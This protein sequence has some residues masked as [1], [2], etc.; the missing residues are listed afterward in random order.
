M[1]LTIAELS[2]N[3]NQSSGF[4][5]AESRRTRVCH[6]S[7]GLTTGGLER[8]LVDFARFHDRT[9]Y[10]LTFVALHDLGRPA[11]EIR[12]T[13]CEVHALHAESKGLFFRIRE[14][15]RLFRE[16]EIDVVHTHNLAPHFN[17][18]LAARLAGA[19]VV[20]HTRHGQRFRGSWKSQFLFRSVGRGVSRFVTVS[21][22]AARLCREADGIPADKVTRIWNGI[23]LGRFQ[24]RG[25]ASQPTAISV[26]RLSPEKDFP[27][28]IRAAAVAVKTIPE[29]RL[30]IVGNGAVRPALEQL[31]AEL[32]VGYCVEL[33]GERNDIPELL[34]NAGFFVSSSLTEGV[35][36]TLL[37]AM[38]VGLPIL[39]TN[40]GG[41]PEVVADGETGRLV[42]AGNVAALAEGIVTVCRN[43]ADW[44]AM[45]RR[46]RERVENHFDIK[47]ML[48]NYE[49]LYDEL[50]VKRND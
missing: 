38:A 37:E 15:S 44:P 21:D 22:D 18:T 46:G 26:A 10:E 42:P 32:N 41:N 24:F 36:L 16:L 13:G 40:V 17:G 35:S 6:V 33:L 29:F 31:I 39:T 45:G 50:L 1:S 2:N 3:A 12:A 47:Q 19:P 28:L 8:L 34:A 5:E 4:D 48:R 11:E 27:T 49:A 7:V 30:Q 25:P 9:R 14:L 20:V 43:S 23:D